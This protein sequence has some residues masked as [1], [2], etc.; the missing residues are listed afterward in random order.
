MFTLIYCTHG[1]GVSA[2]TKDCIRR[3]DVIGNMYTPI[4][5][6]VGIAGKLLLMH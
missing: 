2:V 3:H 6:R 4:L 1:H 5:S